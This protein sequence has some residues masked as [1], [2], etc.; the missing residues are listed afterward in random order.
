MDP[1]IASDEVIGLIAG[2]EVHRRETRKQSDLA[3]ACNEA[4][5]E[6]D[7]L[8][9]REREALQSD[10]PGSR[11]SANIGTVMFEIARVK[12]LAGNPSPPPTFRNTC[13][14][15]VRNP[16]LRSVNSR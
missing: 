11:H 3:A 14:S 9:G 5:G 15:S 6:L 10:G 4:L 12:K 2:I 8:L 1:R 16:R 7:K 13:L